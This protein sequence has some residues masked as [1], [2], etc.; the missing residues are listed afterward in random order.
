MSFRSMSKLLIPP[1]FIS[2]YRKVRYGNAAMK[3]SID[4]KQYIWEGVYKNFSE[5]PLKKNQSEAKGFED[6]NKD[7][8]INFLIEG[9]KKIINHP[10]NNNIIPK[11]ILEADMLLPLLISLAM[12]K[13]QKFKILD[14]GGG[15]G[16]GYLS[17]KRSL[18][19]KN[20]IEYIVF[21]VDNV[22]QAG[23]SFFKDDGLIR[24]ISKLPDKFP[25][26]DLIFLKSVLQYI[27][28][29]TSLLTKICEYDSRYIFFVNFSAVEASSY[30]SLQNNGNEMQMAYWFINISEIIDIMYTNGYSIIYKSA[31]SRIYDQN[32]FPESHR[33]GQTCNLLFEKND[34]LK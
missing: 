32:N 11:D 26:L 6:F 19:K 22:C 14:F 23:N 12:K 13:N 25:E 33:M 10:E 27:E 1:L 8:Y 3:Q 28:D 2:L 5:V 34:T 24:F 21:E 16:N 18:E 29:Y 4:I 30:A 31:L 7:V 15:L 17:L 20:Q 9:A